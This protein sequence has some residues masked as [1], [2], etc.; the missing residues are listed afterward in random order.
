M[1][2]TRGYIRAYGKA[3]EKMRMVALKIGHEMDPDEI[4]ISEMTESRM[5]MYT[6]PAP[7]GRVIT[8]VIPY[9]ARWTLENGGWIGNRIAK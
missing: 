2:S 6:L 8:Q 7:D 3:L 9:D 5:L 4:L 1:R